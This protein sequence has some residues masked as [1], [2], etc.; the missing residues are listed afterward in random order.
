MIC[1][2]KT[3]SPIFEGVFAGTFARVAAS[4]LTLSG[5]EWVEERYP[6]A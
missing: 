2:S 5:G 1:S 6:E 4:S 3:F